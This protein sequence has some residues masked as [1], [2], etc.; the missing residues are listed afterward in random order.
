MTRFNGQGNSITTLNQ[1]VA[2]CVNPFRS[3]NVR[4]IGRGELI[5][6]AKFAAGPQPTLGLVGEQICFRPPNRGDPLWQASRV[7]RRLGGA[8]AG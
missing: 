1:F 5:L 7:E 8:P 2:S 4:S 3:N 6:W